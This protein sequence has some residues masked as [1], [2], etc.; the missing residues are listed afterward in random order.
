MPLSLSRRIRYDR[1]VCRA[2]M[3][4]VFAASRRES[5]EAR[6]ALERM[7]FEFDEDGHLIT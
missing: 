1:R 2:V 4:Y 7:G 6:R 3:K 5:E